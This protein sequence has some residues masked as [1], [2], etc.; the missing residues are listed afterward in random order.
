MKGY[1]GFPLAPNW[2]IHMKAKIA[3]LTIVAVLATGCAT[4]DLGSVGTSVSAA[5]TA[6]KTKVN[7]VQ[8][9]ASKLY[10]AFTT[11]GWVT[12][13]SRKRVQS[14]A[15]V[16]LRGL[17]SETPNGP[18]NAYAAKAGSLSDIRAD[19]YSAQ[20][21]VDQTTKAAEVYLAMAFD[22]T[23]LREELASLQKALIA[24]RQ[25]ELVFKSAFE[26][27]G[28]GTKSMDTDGALVAY[29]KTVDRLRDVTDIFGDRVRRGTANQSLLTS[30]LDITIN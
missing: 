7:V 16:L 10:A 15:S 19:I 29:S 3:L 13:V 22:N 1:A 12:K 21:H 28:M 23:N 9:A 20:Q 14:T 27:K 25:A 11:K 17:D 2:G 18:L 24:S 6:S 5:P 26:A 30:A 4:V 8:R